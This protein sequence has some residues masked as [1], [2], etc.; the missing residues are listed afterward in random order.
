MT[1]INLEHIDDEEEVSFGLRFADALEAA[2]HEWGYDVE[3]ACYVLACDVRRLRLLKQSAHAQANLLEN[4]ARELRE[5]LDVRLGAELPTINAQLARFNYR[6][7]TLEEYQLATGVKAA[8]GYAQT[9]ER[10]DNERAATV[11]FIRR[12][13][14]PNTLMASIQY[15]ADAI[16][17]GE[18][19]RQGRAR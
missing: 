14:A 1:D 8:L 6:P 13:L 3:T 5:A 18:H 4:E 15:I 17:A 12:Q 2:E 7:M 16:E 9:R 10:I 19:I 11:Q